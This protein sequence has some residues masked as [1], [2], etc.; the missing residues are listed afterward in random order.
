M[1]EI[2]VVFKSTLSQEKLKSVVDQILEAGQYL[3]YEDHMAFAESCR[4]KITAEDLSNDGELV[5]FEVMVG[6]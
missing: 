3:L 5:K 2:Q 4:G 6:K 1:N